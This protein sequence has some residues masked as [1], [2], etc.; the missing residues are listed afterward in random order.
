MDENDVITLLIFMVLGGDVDDA[1]I[2]VAIAIVAMCD[3]D[4][5]VNGGFLSKEK[6]LSGNHT[7]GP[8][9]SSSKIKGIDS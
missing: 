9:N 4:G 3:N 8:G 6:S 1:R 7:K 5:S 2:G